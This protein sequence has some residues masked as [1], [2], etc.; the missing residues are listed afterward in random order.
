M[1]VSLTIPSIS[2]KD[3][4]SKKKKG[5]DKNRTIKILC[6]CIVANTSATQQQAAHATY[7]LVLPSSLT[8]VVFLFLM[9]CTNIKQQVRT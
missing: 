4:F 3:T 1:L 8:R 7:Q 9:V 6:K 5:M 2:I